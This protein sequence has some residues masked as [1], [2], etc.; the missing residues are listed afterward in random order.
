MM[1]WIQILC[2]G[3]KRTIIPIRIIYY[4]VTTQLLQKQGA[5]MEKTHPF[6][7]KLFHQGLKS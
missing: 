5:F 2:E 3:F 4:I 7:E 6:K 1:K